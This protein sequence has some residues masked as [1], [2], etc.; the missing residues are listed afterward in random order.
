[1]EISKQNY[2][3]SEANK[4]FMSYSQFKDFLHCESA[5]LA[6][7]NGDYKQP[8]TSALLIGSYV[9][10][11]FEG[12]Q[13]S[14][15][16]KHPEI[17]K[18]DGS[19]KSE[20]VKAENMISRASRDKMFTKYM[21]GEKQVIFTGKIIGVP[22]KCKVDSYHAGKCI[23]DL[24]TVRDFEPTWDSQEHKRVPFVEYWGY[25][26]QGAIYQELVRQKTGA[27]LPFFIAAITKEDVPDIELIN[28]PQERLDECL[29]FVQENTPRFN[30]IK[31]GE[32][33]PKR[34]GKCDYCKETKV[35]TRIVDY[36]DINIKD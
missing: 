15:K 4:Y 22:F 5:A 19:L 11:F 30:A 17:F 21:S 6:K 18:R 29:E 7:V 10:A 32:E 2:Y 12:T 26:L 27:R 33:I 25:D 14:F 16:A 24:K 20:Y 13:E 35:L 3:I 9:D 31:Q 8:V 23:V 36:R 34:C 1:M 28:I